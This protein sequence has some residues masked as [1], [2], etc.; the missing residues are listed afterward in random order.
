MGSIRCDAVP[1]SPSLCRR[2]PPA[3]SGRPPHEREAYHV[4]RSY[5]PPPITVT[6]LLKSSA[7]CHD[8]SV[9][10]DRPACSFF[11]AH[12]NASVGMR[13]PGMLSLA[14]VNQN[15]GPPPPSGGMKPHWR[16]CSSPYEHLQSRERSG[17]IRTD[18][19]GQNS[20]HS[21][22]RRAETRIGR[23]GVTSPI[24][25]GR[26]SGWGFIQLSDGGAWRRRCG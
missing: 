15:C 25:I 6:P 11:G 4:N 16:S 12:H 5:L 24:R 9:G 18:L 22:E 8:A 17:Q 2:A 13:K 10:A 26:V 7:S 3:P 20:A 1:T 23:G 14:H 19:R 21:Y